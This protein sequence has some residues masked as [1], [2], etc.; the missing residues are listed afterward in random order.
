M[1]TSAIYYDPDPMNTVIEA[2]QELLR[3]FRDNEQMFLDTDNREE[4]E[5]YHQ[6]LANQSHWLIR[7]ELDK[8]K[9]IAKDISIEMIDQKIMAGLPQDETN[10]II[11]NYDH[12]DLKKLVLRLRILD[13]E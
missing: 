7:F 11:R 6:R 8:S 5:R 2:D 4:M 3:S 13:I 12:E 9:I 1:A 10:E